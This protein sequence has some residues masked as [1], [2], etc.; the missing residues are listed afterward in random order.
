MQLDPFYLI[1]DSADWVERL[2]PLG[3][4][5]VQLRMKNASDDELRDHIARA[6]AVCEKHQCFLIINDHWRLAIELG[7]KGVHLGQDDLKQAD[8]EALRKAGIAFGISTHD[9]AELD[10]ALAQKPDYVA[11]GP[12]YETLLKKM[13]WAPQ[14]PGRIREWKNKIGALPLVAIGGITPERLNDVFLA[15]ASSAAVVTDIL[16][17]KDPEARTRQWIMATQS[18][19]F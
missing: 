17:A 15:G 1:V 5:L 10:T 14:G 12:I 3:V 2:V 16:T 7:C 4:K 9:E 6:K 13:P 18:Q 8:M 19:G 11:L